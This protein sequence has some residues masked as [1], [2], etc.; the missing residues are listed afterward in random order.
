M[1]AQETAP[2]THAPIPDLDQLKVEPSDDVSLEPISTISQ[3]RALIPTAKLLPGDK[4]YVE[5]AGEPGTPEGGKS[6]SATLPL[7]STNPRSLN[8]EKKVVA[9]LLGKK[10]RVTYTIIRDGEDDKTSD[11]SLVLN[12]LPLPKSE[13]KAALIREAEN[14]GNGPG[15]DLTSSS[16]D[17][18]LRLGIW[19][20]IAEKQRCWIDLVGEKSGGE[21]HS[22]PVLQSDPVDGVWIT[23]GYREVKVPY[24][25]FRKLLNG[26]PLKVIVKVALNQ[27]A[28]KTQAF[29]F[30]ERVYTVKNVVLVKPTIGEVK[31][32]AGATIANPGTTTKTP[33]KL[34]GT[35]AAG[36]K[37]DIYNGTNKLGAATVTGT[38]WAFDTQVLPVNVYVLKAKEQD[39]DELE[40]DSWTV[41]VAA[42]VKPTIGE[43]K[44]SGG[45][46]ISNPGKSSRTPLKL[47]GTVVLG[48]KV[49][50]YNGAT[51][52][53]EGKST[54]PTTWE[55]ETLL[56]S[57][58][59]YVF[60]VIGQ[61]DDL[62]E[63][64][65]WTV[66]VTEGT[67]VIT[68]VRDV[69]GQDVP[70]GSTITVSEVIV[71]GRAVAGRT[72]HIFDNGELKKTEW[73]PENREWRC[74]LANLS[75]SSHEIEAIW[76]G[77]G[78]GSNVWKFTVAVK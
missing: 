32:S 11:P 8:L 72:L 1:T 2:Q 76:A 6:K 7:G 29:D 45:A 38:A 50:I 37:V 21:E 28:D 78:H 3:F 60:K 55:F 77:S 34:K 25:Y 71:F 5:I 44:D 30:E 39:G 4:F 10:M 26:S 59:E 61:H 64:G 54:G 47:T 17:L 23:R 65:T 13:L 22:L 63:S 68:E 70:Y 58:A 51:L 41:T 15:L 40:S 35:V 74:G 20:L 56:L 53:G 48:E 14:G 62:P 52:L 69:S 57:P 49:K 46:T 9:F 36:K 33:L 75:N 24:D 67:V 12:V 18:T 73:V 27:V 66:T 43:V 16:N 42:V 31:D 19:P